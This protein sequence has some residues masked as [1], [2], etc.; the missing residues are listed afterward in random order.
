MSGAH[1]YAIHADTAKDWKPLRTHS[2]LFGVPIGKG[3]TTY[4]MK[5]SGAQSR[6]LKPRIRIF[7]AIEYGKEEADRRQVT[8]IFYGI[9]ISMVLL[10]VAMMVSYRRGYFVYY[11]AYNISML[12]ILAIGSFH[13]ANSSVYLWPMLMFI[14]G[15]CAYLFMQ[16]VLDLRSS[17]R[18]LTLSMDIVAGLFVLASTLELSGVAGTH[19]YVF[20]AAIYI[21]GAISAGVKATAGS[22]PALCLFAGWA[23]FT[24]GYITNTLG[25]YL[26]FSANIMYAAYFGF[27][28]ES[29]LFT[30]AL[31]FEAKL[32]EASALEQNDHAFKQL[33]KV[34]YPH[35]IT[36]I[37]AGRDLEATMPIGEAEACVLC[38]D[39]IGSSTIRH[40]K[41]KV[42]F[43][44]VF[45]HCNE[46]MNRSYDPEILAANAYRVKEMGD[47]FIC[48]VG[49]P[50]K[51]YGDSLAKAAVALAE[52][53]HAAFQSEVDAFGYHLP[54][55]C[56][57]GIAMD[58]VAGYFPE[59]GTKS[60]D[61]YGRGIVL[62]TRYEA[63]R[64]LISSSETSTSMLILQEK[65][66]ASLDAAERDKFVT[67]DLARGSLTV[68][69]DPDA[70]FVYYR[71]LSAAHSQKVAPIRLIA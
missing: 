59:T 49:F 24:V 68:R 2:S 60:Y 32:S 48:S 5:L 23:A 47:G 4:L 7:T 64:K 3:H 20:Q 19:P 51:T 69:D 39:I 50:F 53:L 11:I 71:K 46:V 45:R 63:M 70:K 12:L 14:N 37:R 1:L 67:V 29:V 25:L 56:C 10:C 44:S 58:H 33:A 27:A 21:L 41:A 16:K 52:E 13:L 40:E 54:I 18:R 65:I 26:G 43:Q 28:V 61:L 17:A 9:A 35:Q 34:F 38:F 30:V 22:R 8:V 55:H 66:Y 31:I 15:I 6:R 57:I 42:F 36:Q 62:A